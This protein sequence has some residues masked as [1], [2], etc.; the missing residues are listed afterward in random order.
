MIASRANSERRSLCKNGSRRRKTRRR[1]ARMDRRR[2]RMHSRRSN[3]GQERHGFGR[4]GEEI[5]SRK[6]NALHALGARAKGWTS[7]TS[8]YVPNLHT[9]ELKPWARR[10]GK[11]VFMNH[12]ASR[13]SNDCYVCE[14]PAGRQAGAAAAAVR[15]DDHDPR[16]PRLDHRVERCRPAHH[17]RME[18]G[19]AV[20]HPAE[21][22]GTSIST[23]P[24]G[25]G[26]LSSP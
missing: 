8:I 10:G 4:A 24:A 25:G 9:V 20:R 2:H 23:A 11:G 22:P 1:A 17:L 18:G 3:N 21:L 6:G 26:A 15:G 14:I 19:R 16:R 12:E 7:S 5:R 13:T